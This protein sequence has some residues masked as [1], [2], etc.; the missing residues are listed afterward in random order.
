MNVQKLAPSRKTLFSGIKL[1]L[2]LIPASLAL[3]SCTS[4]DLKAA[5]ALGNLAENLELLNESVSRHLRLMCPLRHLAQPRHVCHGAK[6]SGRITKLRH[7][8]SPQLR[9]HSPRRGFT[10]GVRQCDR[11][12]GRRYGSEGNGQNKI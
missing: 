8:L 9:S 5:Q 6:R 1:L 11:S 10:S 7:P 3:N 4:R 12:T 2:I